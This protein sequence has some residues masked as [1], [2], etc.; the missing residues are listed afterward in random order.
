MKFVPL[1]FDPVEHRAEFLEIN[2]LKNTDVIKVK[3]VK[4]PEK[5]NPNQTHS[6]IFV[7]FTDPDVANEAI[8]KGLVLH[9]QRLEVVKVRQE[10]LICFSCRGTGHMAAACQKPRACGVC[11][12]ADSVR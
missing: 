5:R 9:N 12:E 11:G 7:Q 4:A 6:H 10:P 2:D 3:Y 1:T 8:A